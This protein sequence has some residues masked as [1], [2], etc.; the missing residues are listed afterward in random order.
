LNHLEDR[1][2][3]TVA[4]NKSLGPRPVVGGRRR[5]LGIGQKVLRISLSKC[6][7]C[8]SLV[9]IVWSMG[10]ILLGNVLMPL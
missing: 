4:R 1:N 3:F 5:L 8:P 9:M 7:N 10:F 2:T 6:R